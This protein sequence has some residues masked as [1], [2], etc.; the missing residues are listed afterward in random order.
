MT[1]DNPGCFPYRA[2]Q[3][4]CVLEEQIVGMSQSVI[5]ILRFSKAICG[6]G[7]IQKN[8]KPV[9]LKAA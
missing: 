4:Y 6:H 7:F 2:L 9:K 8:E 1:L 5:S 3:R